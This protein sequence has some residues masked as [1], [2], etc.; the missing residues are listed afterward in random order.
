MGTTGETLSLFHESEVFEDQGDR[1]RMAI[2]QTL[3]FVDHAGVRTVFHWHE[4]LYRFHL[5]DTLTQRYVSVSVRIGSLA[6]QEELARA[7]GHSVATQ[8]RWETRYQAEGLEGLQNGKPTGRPTKMPATLDVV[9]RKW[10]AQGVSNREMARRLQLGEATIHRALRRLGLQRQPRISGKRLWTEEEPS[11]NVS[12]EDAAD[13]VKGAI[14]R[15][16]PEKSVTREEVRE[17]GS[18]QDARAPVP[19]PV[20]AGSRTVARSRANAPGGRVS[21]MAGGGQPAQENGEEAET[22]ATPDLRTTDV[23]GESEG[24]PKRQPVFG[25]CL[26]DVLAEYEEKGFSIDCDPDHRGGDRGL[27]R[28]GQL[29]DA[30]PL[31]KNRPC[32]RQAGVLLAIP[33]LVKSSLLDV[34]SRIYHSL[35]PAF[36]GLRTSVVVL[37]VAALLRIKRP[38]E[39]KEYNPRELGHVIGLDRMPEVKTVRAKVDA[40]A[41]RKLAREVMEAMAQQRIDEDS[42]RV[43]FL[44]VDGHVQVYYGKSPLA[45]TKKA[46]H[47]VA[48]PAATDH[49]VHDAYG[50]PLLVV[51]SEMNE[52]LTQM[53]EPILEDVRKLIGDRRV[54]VIF[55]RGGY[56][57]KLFA[58]LDKQG[59]DVMTYRK[60]KVR[61]W[62]LTQ[63]AEQELIV[64]G[65]RYTYRLAERKRVRV[66]RLRPKRKKPCSGAGPQF[67]WMREVRV[68]RSD[69]RQTAILTTNRTLES[70]AVPYRQFH[71][72]RQ[73]N[74]FKYMD[75]EFALDALLEYGVEDVSPEADRPNPQ[76][77]PLE[78]ELTAARSR[79]QHL[80]AELGAAVGSGGPS[81]Q[82]TVKGFKIAHAKLRAEL[83]EAE[84]EVARIQ[85]ELEQ[86]P[87]RI[88]ATDLKTLKTEKKLISNTIKITAYQVETRLLA[89]LTKY[90]CRTEDEGRT[91]LQAA[92]Q[93]TARIEVREDELYVEISPQSSPHRTKALAALCAELN[94][95]DTKFPGTHLRLNLAVQPHEPLINAKG[96]CQ[97]F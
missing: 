6:T 72:W 30:L 33:L 41:A 68:L 27:A 75:A 73:E 46:Q 62:P 74:F 55:D 20:E 89:M 36:Y 78:R 94:T 1:R 3:S 40:L 56:S 28:M 5:S 71:R 42:D 66:G 4:P 12:E 84:A 53:L 50:E 77:R 90:Y 47:Q 70:V 19:V 65:R 67:L 34:F 45:K 43:A 52:G 63:F 9:L 61:P 10:F 26:E 96:E 51:T 13:V 44:Y 80:Q 76:R 38:E 16:E 15:Q 95:F 57:P 92:F 69:G 23:V 32:L 93:S 29:E 37:F 24:E 59:F 91:L 18:E 17:V 39:F 8:R 35:G 88:P 22:A 11:R 48:K 21:E 83:A 64:D 79:V 7:F 25:E 60:G 97:E 58:R 86:L 85:E 54:T 31:F 82:R 87:R 81:R 14:E 49:W 2:N